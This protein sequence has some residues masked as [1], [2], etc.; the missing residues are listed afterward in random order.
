VTDRQDENTRTPLEGGRDIITMQDTCLL[1]I[2][3]IRIGN[4]ELEMY[5]KKL[6]E[7]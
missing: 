3:Y 5:P 7:P 6:L 1:I 2:I 4:K